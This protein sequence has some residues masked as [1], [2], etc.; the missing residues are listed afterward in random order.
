MS[1]PGKFL[2]IQQIADVLQVHRST[3]SRILAR[4]E[5]PSRQVGDSPRVDPADFLA[6]IEAG[7]IESTERGARHNASITP[8]CRSTGRPRKRPITQNASAAR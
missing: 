2:T 5:I 8:T 1:I 7:K 3:V 4:G 6:W